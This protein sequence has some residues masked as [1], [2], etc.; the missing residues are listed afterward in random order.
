MI[1][2][3]GTV[4]SV[5]L[6]MQMQT[7]EKGECSIPTLCINMYNNQTKWFQRIYWNLKN[8]PCDISAESEIVDLKRNRIAILPK[9]IFR[10]LSQCRRLDLSH[11]EIATI[12][13]GAFIGLENVLHL[14]LWVNLI[15]TIRNDMWIGLDKLQNLQLWRNEISKIS[16]GSFQRLKSLNHLSLARN[17]IILLEAGAFSGLESLQELQLYKNPLQS[18]DQGSFTRVH[19]PL[20]LI[21]GEDQV[22]DCSG[23][24]WLKAEQLKMTIIFGMDNYPRCMGGVFWGD[25][26]CTVVGKWKKNKSRTEKRMETRW[27]NLVL[28]WSNDCFASLFA[29]QIPPLSPLTLLH[30]IPPPLWLQIQLV[31][32]TLPLIPFILITFKVWS[33]TI[34]TLETFASTVHGFP[35]V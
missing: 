12:V 3:W 23:M 17:S 4:A 18:L 9:N 32:F 10:H 1:S 25:L 19:R 30:K 34:F 7:C 16:S 2:A 35:Y 13:E 26:Q 27:S 15:L 24:C 29:Q 33:P 20:I 28:Q 5:L 6:V 31:R 22:F 11:N 21:L 14:D 8:V